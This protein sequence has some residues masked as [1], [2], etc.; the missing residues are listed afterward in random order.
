MYIQITIIVWFS[1]QRSCEPLFNSI[2]YCILSFEKMISGMYLGEIVRLVLK[3]LISNNQLFGGESSTKFDTDGAF[4]TRSLCAID[5]G[6][7]MSDLMGFKSY[8][9]SNW[10]K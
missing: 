7:V 8:T 6:Y 4:S 1:Q 9:Y 3:D 10:Q 2:I 5:D